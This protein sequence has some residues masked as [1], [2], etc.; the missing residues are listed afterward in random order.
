MA[1]AITGFNIFLIT[2]GGWASLFGLFSLL[3]K[4]TYFLS[5]PCQLK[6]I[7]LGVQCLG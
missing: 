6:L 5:E 1:F 3:L 2:F 4:E 7:A